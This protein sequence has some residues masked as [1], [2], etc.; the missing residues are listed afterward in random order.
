M[1]PAPNAPP[2]RFADSSTAQR[3]R[4]IAPQARD[5]GA[6]SGVLIFAALTLSACAS[7]AAPNGGVASLDALRDVQAACAAKGLTMQLK[8]EGDPERI[9]AYACVRK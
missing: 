8:P 9:D 6:V 1:M 5:G 2:V 3:G 4:W 7:A